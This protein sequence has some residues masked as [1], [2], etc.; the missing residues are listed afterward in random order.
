VQFKNGGVALGIF[1]Y[2]IVSKAS[3]GTGIKPFKPII[4]ERLESRILLSGEGLLS[5]LNLPDPVQNTPAINTDIHFQNAD[6]LE[7]ND[8]AQHTSENAANQQVRFDLIN[9]SG[10]GVV[11]DLTGLSGWSGF[12]DLTGDSGLITL[13][14][15]G[16]YTLTAHGTGDQYGYSYCFRLLETI[17]I[18]LSLGSMYS[19]TFVGSSQA[20]LF[21][22]NIPTASPLKV[23]LDDSSLLIHNELYIKYGSAPTRTD[24]HYSSTLA[25][26]SDEE[27]LVKLAAPGTWYLIVYAEYISAPSDYILMTSTAGLILTSVTPD[28]HGTSA[29]ATLTLS[30]AGFDAGTT[31]E[32]VGSDETVYPASE[33]TVDSFTQVTATFEAGVVPP[34]LYSIR[35][36]HADGDRAEMTD[37]F[38]M[39]AGGEAVLELDLIL[40]ESLGWHMV[41]TFYIEY[42]NTGDVAMPAPLIQLLPKS[43]G[44]PGA[45]M[46][47]DSSLI[48]TALSTYVMPDGFTDTIQILGSSEIPGILR[49][50][51]SYRVPVY[52]AGWL[53][54]FWFGSLEFWFGANTATETET[55]DWAGMKNELRP[56]WIQDDAWEA[57]LDNN[58]FETFTIGIIVNGYYTRDNVTDNTLITISKPVKNYVTGGG[59]IINEF[60]A[61]VFAGDVGLRNH[62]ME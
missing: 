12:N 3:S 4:L 33:I 13:P 41:S 11:F 26:T 52:Y 21:S 28:R 24:Y 39:I 32:L 44:Q 29:D 14:A 45:I 22:I 5:F 56:E 15:S 55:I 51:E 19:G 47:L 57:D 40:P 34:G 17:Q 46:T 16:E 2:T 1:R 20:Q 61:G 37:A 58:D 18:D 6:F 7:L 49:P 8:T 25:G 31:V 43:D 53:L 54:P 48:T 50:G 30:G 36:T 35:V 60:S 9:K 27:L 10:N 59:H 38:E 23:L 42:A 62:V